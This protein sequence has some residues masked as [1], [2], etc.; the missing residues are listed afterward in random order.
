MKI[1]M[2]KILICLIVIISC[3][4]AIALAANLKIDNAKLESGIVID[5]SKTLKMIYGESALLNVSGAGS[6]LVIESSNTSIAKVSRFT[7][8]A[9]S[10]GQTYLTAKSGG[11]QNKI[12]IMVLEPGKFYRE[13]GEAIAKFVKFTSA[14]M[15]GKISDLSKKSQFSML[16][17]DKAVLTVEHS[18]TDPLKLSSSDE[19]IVS[20]EDKTITAKSKGRATITATLGTREATLT[21]VVGD[22]KS[23]SHEHSFDIFV[24]PYMK[25]TCTRPGKDTYKCSCGKTT[26]VDTPVDEN[27]HS[28]KL[29]VK[30]A[31]CTTPK[32]S[33]LECKL[34]GNIT[35]KKEEGSPLGHK[36]DKGI[37]TKVATTV[38]EGEKVYTCT[39]CKVKK[40][41]KLPV[42]TIDE[43]A[44]RIF[45]PVG[46]FK[47]SLGQ[48]KLTSND[49]SIVKITNNGI[50]SDKKKAGTT[51]VI[52]T[53]SNGSQIKYVVT[54]YT[55][56]TLKTKY[57]PLD[58][59][60]SI[61]DV[62]VLPNGVPD[63]EYSK[64]KF[65]NFSNNLISCNISNNKISY[66]RKK[67]VGQTNILIAYEDS[68][69]PYIKETVGIKYYEDIIEEGIITAGIMNSKSQTPE[70]V[71]FY[72]PMK[73][74]MNCSVSQGTIP[75]IHQDFN[76]NVIVFQISSNSNITSWLSKMDILISI[77]NKYLTDKCNVEI[78]AHGEGGDIAVEFAEKILEKGNINCLY[79]DLLEATKD[80][81]N[82]RARKIVNLVYEGAIVNLY[83]GNS[84]K[85]QMYKNTIKTIENAQSLF[86]ARGD[87][88]VGK[89]NTILDIKE[90]DHNQLKNIV[91]KLIRNEAIK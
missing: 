56:P 80:G 67:D 77:A 71:V 81:S 23:N 55:M 52:D 60:L 76:S 79:V 66:S 65:L 64:Y 24:K 57:I 34:C 29:V 31:T 19:N 12:T 74:D 4:S 13:N 20:L 89:F 15:N 87:S 88:F 37:V 91:P 28:Y 73:S 43:S 36:F 78:I 59:E 63:S 48:G 3:V 86:G 10:I 68:K 83:T 39:V 9:N 22:A 14:N 27:A 84:S 50:L 7:V 61:Q 18:T 72:F 44:E 5:A 25:A 1:L 49:K 11:K 2:K 69:K 82:D 41:E 85:H 30:K 45:I 46:G 40:T 75:V 53:L 8:T 62:I 35:D 21:V 38:E 51:E 70:K 32:M 6:D 42:I 17:G 47:L 90:Y 33:C 54:V 58:K 26:L 16:P